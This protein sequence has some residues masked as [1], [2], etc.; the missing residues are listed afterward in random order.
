M[1][2]EAEREESIDK[3]FSSRYNIHIKPARAMD[4]SRFYLFSPY[5]YYHYNCMAFFV[6]RDLCSEASHITE[7]QRRD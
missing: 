6:R 7:K 2:N 3:H 1:K 5:N 4:F